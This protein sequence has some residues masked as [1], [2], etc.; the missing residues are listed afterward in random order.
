VHADRCDLAPSGP[1]TGESILPTGS[2]PPPAERADEHF[3]ES[4]QIPVQILPVSLEVEDGIAHELSRPVEGCVAAALNLV[5][6]HAPSRQKLRGGAVVATALRLSPQRDDRWMLDEEEDVVRLVSADPF[7]RKLPLN[8]E[9]GGVGE[10]AE[11][12]DGEGLG[13]GESRR[14]KAES[15]SCP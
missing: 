3:L 1:D 10:E 6:L 11:I 15:R 8:I 12:A 2:Y 13:S 4:A 5:E 9:R 7:S 14:Q